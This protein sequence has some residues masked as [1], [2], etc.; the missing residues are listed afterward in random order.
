MKS[1]HIPK[2]KSK[3]KSKTRK[4]SSRYNKLSTNTTLNKKH[5][6]RN[7]TIKLSKN[8]IELLLLFS[9]LINYYILL[10]K[11]SSSRIAYKNK[12]ITFGGCLMYNK[13]RNIRKNNNNL[14]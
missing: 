1:L 7:T 10:N 5:S 12:I 4:Y 9:T 14:S 6:K 3:S 2:S 8:R 11:T 13:K